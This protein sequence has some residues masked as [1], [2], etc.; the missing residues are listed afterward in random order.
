[1]ALQSKIET[2][3][4]TNNVRFD[5]DSA[6]VGIDNSCTACISHVAQDFIGPLKDS[7][8][9]IK[10]FAGSRTKEVK[11]GTLV[12]IWEDDEGKMSK[13]IIPNSYYVPEGNMRPLSP[14]HWAKTQKSK[15]KKNDNRPHGTICQTTSDDVTLMWNNRQSKLTIPLGRDNNVATFHLACGYSRYD[16]FCC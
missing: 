3:K 11:I 13:F 15:Q 10:G 1:M 6:P 2:G 4:Y 12:W 7:G 9:T 14:Q 5:T 8:R 16:K